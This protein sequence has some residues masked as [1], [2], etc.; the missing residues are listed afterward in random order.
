MRGRREKISAQQSKAVSLQLKFSSSLIF[1]LFLPISIH[2]AIRPSSPLPP[3]TL[4]SSPPLLLTLP[5]LLFKTHMTLCQIMLL[6]LADSCWGFFFFP[7]L[8]SSHGQESRLINRSARSC[9][10]RIYTQPLHGVCACTSQC[11]DISACLWF[12]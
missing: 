1:S 2:L 8:F 7:L 3:P 10:C 9:P 11:V 4:S 12:L 5:L 6:D